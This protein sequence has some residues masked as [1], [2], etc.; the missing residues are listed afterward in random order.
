MDNVLVTVIVPTYNSS[1]TVIETLDSVYNQ[2]YQDIELI[3]TD[4]GSKDESVS[5][6]SEWLASHAGR[7]LRTKL[8]E[9]HV[10]TGVSANNNRALKEVKG[11]WCK[12]IAAD[13]RLLPRCIE[14]FIN[15]VTVHPDHRIVFAKVVGFGNME[16]AK[17]WPFK[18]VKWLFDNLSFKEMK[19]L[20][21]QTN[22]LPAASTFIKKDVFDEIGFFDES[23]PLL[24]DWPFW[25]KAVFHDIQ[26]HFYDEYVAEYR[27]STSSVSQI[28]N[29][30][31]PMYLESAIKSSAYARKHESKIGFL[32]SF[33][34]WTLYHKNRSF[35]GGFAHLFNVFNPDYYVFKRVKKKYRFFVINSESLF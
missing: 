28:E 11:S 18:N 24:E 35:M 19:I 16:A 10:N 4:D 25:I 33:Y 9:S 7:F 15:Y 6:C 27:F 14:L 22:F 12:F 21:T 3:V 29:G 20:L 17:K 8:I 13:D 31:S 2:T 1:R 34:F 32:M 23:I 30:M 26:L 5:I